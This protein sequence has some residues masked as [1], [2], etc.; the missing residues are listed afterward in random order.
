ML[1]NFVKYVS[2]NIF[3]MIGVSVYILADT[4][5]ISVAE[6]ADGITALNLALPLYGVIYGTGAMI[7][8][9]AATR[10]ALL[11]AE[12]DREADDF[13]VNAA[14]WELIL[15]IP[16]M[17]CGLFA[18]GPILRLMGA[19]AAI[20]ALGAGYVRIILTAAPLF[21]VNYVFTAFVR[22]DGDPSRAMAATIAGSIFNII[23]D[24]VFMFIFGWGLKGAAMATVGAPV[25]G[26]IIAGT[27][28][29]SR[30]NTI[31]VKW[32]RPKPKILAKSCQLGVS[33]FIGEMSSAVT[34]VVFNFLLLGLMGNVAVAAYGVV[35]NMA[36]VAV[37]IFNGVA[38]GSQPLISESY[39]KSRIK[40]AHTYFNMGVALA[41]GI[42]IALVVLAWTCTK[43]MV[44]IF[45]SEGNAGMAALAYDALRLYF[46]GYLFAGFNITAT[47]YMSAIGL[48]REAFIAS[49]LRGLVAIV[50]CACIM[51]AAF[52]ITGV[53]L[54]FAAAEL[55]TA[56]YVTIAVRP[57]KVMAE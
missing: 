4:Y 38:Q 40:E 24:Y 31:S 19:D 29:W 2:Q 23:F 56:V 33:G 37:A 15:S 43:P 13:F 32:S 28:F 16:I 34:T 45:N 9:G 55:I 25:T 20:E 5:F 8:V 41:T 50:G 48:A 21:M 57:R 30:S 22:N 6:G 10:Y 14:L 44:A 17:A 3:G 39:G 35:A 54:S 42:A 49:L 36:L 7:G 51:A 26:I 27:H 11:K 53:W 18:A 1:R 12:G 47:G 52:G 46:L